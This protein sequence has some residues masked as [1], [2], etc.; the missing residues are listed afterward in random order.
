MGHNGHNGRLDALGHNGH[1]GRLIGYRTPVALTETEKFMSLEIV[2][3]KR[4]SAVTWQS[5]VYSLYCR[6]RN[7]RAFMRLNVTEA[8]VYVS[9]CKPPYSA[10]SKL[11]LPVLC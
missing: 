11:S 3:C 2:S 1:I 4:Q 9:A 7:Y 10:N 6:N 8:S 5:A